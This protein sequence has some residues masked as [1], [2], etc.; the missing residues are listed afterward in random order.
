MIVTRIGQYKI[1]QK[2]ESGGQATVYK[3]NHSVLGRDVALKILHPH[4][5]TDPDFVQ[6]FED[7]GKILAKMDNPRIVVV[8]DAGHTGQLYWIAM[9]WLYGQTA[10]DRIDTNGKLPID[11]VVR[12]AIQCASALEYSHGR[13]YIHR[14]IKP[15]NIMILKNKNVKLLD[16]G[17]AALIAS[18]Q[19]AKTRIG[20]VEYMS[21]EQ[22][23][24]QADERSDIY[25]LGASLYEMLTGQLPPELA[26]KPLKQIRQLNSKVP[27]WLEDIITSS[28]SHNP[29]NRPQTA[30][31]FRKYL[32]SGTA[33]SS[34]RKTVIISPPP[35]AL[36]PLPEDAEPAKP[37]RFLSVQKK[38]SS[39][40][41]TNVLKWERSPTPNTRYMI[42]RKY[43]GFPQSASDGKRL[44]IIDNIRYEDPNPRIGMSACYA[45]YAY[46]AY[47]NRVE[48]FSSD[49]ARSFSFRTAD[50]TKLNAIRMP[51]S[52]V[53]LSW[54]PPPHV[55]RIRVKRS[56]FGKANWVLDKSTDEIIIPQGATSRVV[57]EKAPQNKHLT[58]TIYCQFEDPI[59]RGIKTS[60]GVTTE[61][62]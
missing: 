7:E 38:I 55:Y 43:N 25:S 56:E 9:E 40:I 21:Y 24:G 61:V 30:L 46:Q 6:K 22:F 17:I 35:K 51:P 19:K 60:D 49:A 28:L 4:L 26:L 48:V 62:Y 50:V 15:A 37:P 20:T 13:D 58:Y 31:E 33:Q 2:V 29:E 5:I 53:E 10:R 47:A 1:V 36:P 14:D 32:S 52:R 16:F 11:L 27:S 12:I 42:L 41:Y 44:D 57:D 54:V 45:V 39:G 8:Y 59:E 3:A 23:S 34:S 18:G